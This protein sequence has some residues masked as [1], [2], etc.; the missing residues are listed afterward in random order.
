MEVRVIRRFFPELISAVGSC[1]QNISDYCFSRSLIG[2]T[3][4]KEVLESAGTDD[5]KARILILAVLATVERNPTCFQ[6]FI[7]ILENTLPQ[8][9]EDSLLKTI[10]EAV[11]GET[12][13]S[14]IPPL[15]KSAQLVPQNNLSDSITPN[16]VTFQLQKP[17]EATS[18]YSLHETEPRTEHPLEQCQ[19]SE[20]SAVS[21][22]NEGMSL[23]MHKVVSSESQH[24]DTSID[25]HN[26]KV[27]VTST[28][29]LTS[30]SPFLSK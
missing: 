21:I 13:L 16:S 3:K 28:S 15:L 5:D 10:K 11:D 27:Y 25:D 18:S 20:I 17:L 6:T 30:S 12:E 29:S 26:C 24:S 7:D 19:D 1:V 23:N 14:H 22:E 8:G 4:R 2:E 9:V